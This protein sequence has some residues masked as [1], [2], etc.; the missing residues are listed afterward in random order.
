[1]DAGMDD[2]LSKPVIKEKLAAAIERWGSVIFSTK[3]TAAIEQ[4]VSTTDVGSVD[5]LIDWERLHELSENNPEFELEL[6][7]IFV[8]D[9]Q[10]R[11]EVVKTAIATHDFQELA[12]QAHQI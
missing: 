1:L 6:V 7:Q 2:Y 11:I 12:L 9:I 5:L 8:E 10:S 4:T 3:E